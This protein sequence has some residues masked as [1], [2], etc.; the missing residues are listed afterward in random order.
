MIRALRLIAPFVLLAACAAPSVPVYLQPGVAPAQARVD[1]AQCRAQTNAARP[2]R[3]LPRGPT[4][5]V[6]VG[7]CV[8]NVCVGASNDGLFDAADEARAEA[9]GEALGACMGSRGYRLIDLAP[10]PGGRGRV[11]AS[12]P[13]DERGLCA[14]DGEV[15]VPA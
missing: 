12:H 1:F 5:T 3:L 8:G 4:I 15:A 2:G 11:V 13:F 10:C 7:R 6:G 14:L 9:R